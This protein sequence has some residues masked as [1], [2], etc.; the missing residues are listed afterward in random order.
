MK[1]LKATQEL[2]GGPMGAHVV[3]VEL[4]AGSPRDEQGDGPQEE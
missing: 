2:L 4:A 1:P 3:A